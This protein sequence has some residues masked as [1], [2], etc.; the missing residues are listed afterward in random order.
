AEGVVTVDTA[1]RVQFINHAACD[2]MGCR[3]HEAAGRDVAQLLPLV[4]GTTDA[5]FDWAG[6]IL[7]GNRAVELPPQT[8]LHCG[9]G[10]RLTVDGRGAPMHDAHGRT[11][12][13]VLV[14]RDVS[15]R[16]QLEEELQRAARLESVGLLAG[17]I[18]HDFNNILAVVMG[19]LTLSTMDE[20]VKAS[21]AANWLREAEQATLRARDLTPQLLTFAKGGEPVRAA[22][23][24]PELVHEAAR[25][26]LH[27]ASARC[28]FELA[29]DLRPARV[30][31]GQIGQVVQ[32]LVLNAAQAMPGGG[33]IRITLRNE[34]VVA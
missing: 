15:A 26:A 11:V 27:G 10:R 23:Q 21:R 8:R 28:E 24:L 6:E 30:D 22:V 20:A 5:P 14:L 12:G 9:D 7:N 34:T 29:D 17:G 19:N 32:N 3:D 31:P 2:L 16:V 1:G 33:V 13:A 18:A 25:F 4:D